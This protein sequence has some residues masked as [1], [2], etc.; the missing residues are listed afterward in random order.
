MNEDTFDYDDITVSTETAVNEDGSVTKTVDTSGVTDGSSFEVSD[1]DTNATTTVDLSGTNSKVKVTVGDGN[2]DVQL[3]DKGGSTAAIAEGATGDKQLKA[4]SGGDRL[5]NQSTDANVTMT[6][7]AGADTIVAA[8]GDN[9]VIDLSEGGADQI[10]APNGANVEGYDA[11]SGAEFMT[12]VTDVFDAIYDGQITFGNGSFS[13]EGSSGSITTDRNAGNV[14]T[15]TTNITDRYGRQTQ[16]SSTYTAGGT[17][18]GRNARRARLF[19]G[20][21]DGLKDGSS[22][23]LGSSHNDTF[24]GGASDVINTGAGTNQLTLKNTTTGAN[25]GGAA[26]DQTEAA[27]RK[28]TNNIFGY[29][30]LLNF[31]RQTAEAL[32]N[33][34]A[35]F[36]NGLLVTKYGKTTNNFLSGTGRDLAA[37]QAVDETDVFAEADAT[38]KVDSTEAKVDVTLVDSEHVVLDARGFAGDAVLIGNEN[39]NVIYGGTGNNSLWGGESGDDTLFGGD[40]KNEFYYTQ[41]NGDDVIEGA[42]DGDVVKLLNISVSD[43]EAKFSSIDDDKVVLSMQ[44][45]GS[46]TINGKADVTIELNDGSQ[47]KANRD[48]KV[49]DRK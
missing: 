26:I 21:S 8:G 41:G 24:I 39:D 37:L 32:A 23:M 16:V 44:D 19:V 31:I 4:G 7:G 47:W 18:D 11:D 14:G 6:G 35:R 48:K 2:Q 20:N 36:V 22:L 15:M 10:Y 45:G 1:E 13:V 29:D 28:T 46:L 27:T 9:E 5:V 42:K 30:P 49:F 25:A 17:A 40:G 33:M 12:G 34:Q 38:V 43:L 3:S